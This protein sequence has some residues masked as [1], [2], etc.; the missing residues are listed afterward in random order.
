LKF[1]QETFKEVTHG[2][3]STNLPQCIND[4][5]ALML[6]VKKIQDDFF[7]KIFLRGNLSLIRSVMKNIIV[8]KQNMG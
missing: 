7:K 8:N 6:I 3:V 4:L 2:S 5:H 1:E